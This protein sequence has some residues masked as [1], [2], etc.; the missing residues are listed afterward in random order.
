MSAINLKNRPNKQAK[1]FTK[2]YERNKAKGR[3]YIENPAHPA[4]NATLNTLIVR[5]T[6]DHL[7]KTKFYLKKV[8]IEHPTDKGFF[9][10]AYILNESGKK[11]LQSRKRLK[12]SGLP[13]WEYMYKVDTL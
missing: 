12:S 3:T 6:L 1:G 8:R 13:F 2:H 4:F 7:A 5:G 10:D 11:L 9:K